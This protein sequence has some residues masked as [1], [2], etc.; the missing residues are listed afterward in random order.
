MCFQNTN[1]YCQWYH[2]ELSIQFPL[3]LN[4]PVQGE[5]LLVYMSK[6]PQSTIII[7]III[8]KDINLTFFNALTIRTNA[9]KSTACFSTQAQL[10]LSIVH[11]II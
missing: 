8:Q 3:T 4:R 5:C 2:E 7:I 9:R 1:W 11:L 10:L 6:L